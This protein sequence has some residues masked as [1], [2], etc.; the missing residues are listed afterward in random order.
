ME[1]IEGQ[2]LAHVIAELRAARGPSPPLTTRRQHSFPVA[3]S[4]TTNHSFMSSHRWAS[5]GRCVGAMLISWASCTRDIKPSN[6][7]VDA[8]GHLWITDFGLATGNTLTGPTMTGDMLGTL[9]YMSP[10]QAAGER[11]M[12]DARTDIY[13]LGVTLYELPHS[14]QPFR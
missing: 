6:L 12:P 14:N 7:M 11:R 4:V 3:A 9:R 10:E 2:T 13:S 1:Y 5:G 8:T